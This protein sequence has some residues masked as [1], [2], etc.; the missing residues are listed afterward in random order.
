M[1]AGDHDIEAGWTL[2]HTCNYRCDYCFFPP[3]LLGSKRPELAANAD[4]QRAFDA[5]GLVWLINLTGGEPSLHPAF[6]DLCRR[7]TARHWLSVNSN[8]VPRAWQTFADTVDPARVRMVHAAFHPLERQARDGDGA[9]ITH[10]N[11]LRD[12]AFPIMAS[13]VATPQ[14]LAGMAAIARRLDA[15]GIVVVPKLLRTV[16]LGKPY[17]ASY[18]EAEREQF[19]TALTRAR[20]HYAPLLARLPEPPP[21][22]P[23]DDDTWLHD[24]PDYVGRRCGAGRTFVQID[25]QGNVRHCPDVAQ[26]NLLDGTFRRRPGDVICTTQFCH[27]WCERHA[28]TRE[29]ALRVAQRRDLIVNIAG[30]AN[31]LK[32]QGGDDA[33]LR[34]R[35]DEQLAALRRAI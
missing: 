16:Y 29:D 27:Y 19:R 33:G 25:P 24:L 8:L 15:Y 6:A 35:L 31:A 26:G 2:F 4:W 11:R 22:Y 14:V 10:F 17:P 9:F 13:V 7:L 5:T 18:T 23:F 32:V 12:K 3:A 21:I 30:T 1:R 34:Q 20:A 28:D